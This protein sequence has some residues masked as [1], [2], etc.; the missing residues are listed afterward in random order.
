MATRWISWTW[1]ESGVETVKATS[2]RASAGL[3][4]LPSRPTVVSFNRRTTSLRLQQNPVFGPV[5]IN[6]SIAQ[7]SDVKLEAFD[8]SGRKLATLASGFASAGSHSATW[9]TRSVPAGIYF[10]RLTAA[11]GQRSLK[12]VVGR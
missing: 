6:F 5:R 12:A 2:Q 10:L 4:G 8:R 1:A 11:S 7:A 3:P 9:D